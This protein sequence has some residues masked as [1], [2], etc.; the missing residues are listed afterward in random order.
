MK[1]IK[2]IL[3][4]GH[5]GNGVLIFFISIIIFYVSG[6]YWNWDI[7]VPFRLKGDIITDGGTLTLAQMAIRGDGFFSKKGF[8]SP[9]VSNMEWSIM[10]GS[11]HFIL[12]KI[13]AII[14]NSPEKLANIYF[15]FT[16]PLCA[17]F[18]YYTL[19]RLKINTNISVC[20]SIIYTYVPGH[21]LRNIS[22]L[23]I[24]SCFALPLM[25]LGCIYILNDEL[26]PE[27]LDNCNINPYLGFSFLKNRKLIEGGLGSILV[28]FSSIYF[29]A[30]S[31]MVHVLVGFV[32]CLS[33]TRN[34]KKNIVGV[35]IFLCLDFL[36]A[37][38]TV[39][40]PIII[41]GGNAANQ[42]SERIR[43]DIDIYGLKLS[44]L[45][46]P[47]S[48][49]RIPILAAI[50]KLYT[51][52]YTENENA[53]ASLGFI[54][55]VTFLFS[56]I[57]VFINSLKKKELQKIQTIGKI[58]ILI[59]LI[60]TVGGICEIVGLVSYSI[61]CY[62]RFSFIIA[63]FSSIALA[64][65]LNMLIDKIKPISGLFI[66][67]VL[68]CFSVY[69]QTPADCVSKEIASRNAKIWYS[70]KEF[71]RN[72]EANAEEGKIV[73]YPSKYSPLYSSIDEVRSELMKGYI[74]TKFTSFSIG[75]QEGWSTDNWI[76]ELEKYTSEQKIKLAVGAGFDGILMYKDGWKD[77]TAFE[78]T[79]NDFTTI[80]GKKNMII[81]SD[82][83]WYYFSFADYKSILSMYDMEKLKSMCLKIGDIRFMNDFIFE[84]VY[85]FNSNEVEKY[86][87][88]G[89]SKS[90]SKF[91][92]S[93]GSTSQ[94]QARCK[95]ESY[96][97]L[98][99]LIN[100]AKVYRP[101]VLT[102]QVNGQ[103][104]GSFSLPDESE[105]CFTI[106]RNMIQDDMVQITIH[107][108]NPI[109]PESQGESNDKRKLAV[110]YK[111]IEIRDLGTNIKNRENR[112]DTE[113]LENYLN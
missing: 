91:R 102:I 19:I 25:V 83:K 54:L 50:R 55:S 98:Q 18:M 32:V 39:I 44:Q 35:F 68:I 5:I 24:G 92:W 15:I 37:F 65:F 42:F 97:D 61:R 3:N 85:Q 67:I 80:L 53:Y 94:I 34:Q 11:I 21:L 74:H 51:N 66:L 93:I 4:Y 101:Q 64:Y 87:I 111:T 88:S 36:C 62:N 48:N 108:S 71:F 7:N 76:K 106:P 60:A 1:S 73:I 84:K 52:S 47:I 59:F 29:C 82:E 57:L 31:M 49:H 77:R 16:F 107:Y 22:H 6:T 38:F 30:F 8:W 45:I 113:Y 90:E 17:W 105:I 63:C 109:S 28:G 10:D 86:L 12:I 33:K 69:D 110:A 103:D 13:F 95:K 46:F 14:I 40:L 112:E 43:S 58:N 23:A 41:S 89:F 99:V 78:E 56:I 96:G 2:K 79:A 9:K 75:Y 70:E 81:S 72:V 104:I 20:I 27:R 100:Y 26:I